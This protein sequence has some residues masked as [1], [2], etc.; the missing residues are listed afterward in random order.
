MSSQERRFI[1]LCSKNFLNICTVTWNVRCR[2]PLGVMNCT[3]AFEDSVVTLVLIIIIP[4]TQIMITVFVCVWHNG[5][6]ISPDASKK[7]S[8]TFVFLTLKC[9]YLSI[10]MFLNNYPGN[11]YPPPTLF[12][13]PC[14]TGHLFWNPTVAEYKMHS[15]NLR[16]QFTSWNK[17]IHLRTFQINPGI[18]STKQDK[19]LSNRILC[20]AFAFFNYH[21]L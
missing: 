12:H 15:G 17:C 13:L 11:D 10:L 2:M 5:V 19:G 9:M 6:Q 20:N 16:Q 18:R 21:L 1:S 7:Y 3:G 8:N 14:F 4:C